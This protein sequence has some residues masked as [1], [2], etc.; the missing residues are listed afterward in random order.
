MKNLF[1]ENNLKLSIREIDKIVSFLVWKSE[2]WKKNIVL[3][4]QSFS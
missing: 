3:V 4:I 2:K 1:Y